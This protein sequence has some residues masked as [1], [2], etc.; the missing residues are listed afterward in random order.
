MHLAEPPTR[1]HSASFGTSIK[2]VAT[3]NQA[4]AMSMIGNSSIKGAAG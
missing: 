2:A 1:H 3:P 4:I